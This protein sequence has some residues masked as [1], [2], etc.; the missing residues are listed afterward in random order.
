MGFTGFYATQMR[1]WA[2]SVALM[3][4]FTAFY[5]T[6][7][8]RY[9]ISVSLEMGF[10]GFHATKMKGLAISVALVVGFCLDLIL[11]E[12]KVVYNKYTS[13]IYN[14]AFRQKSNQNTHS[15]FADI[16]VSVL[17]P[18][19]PLSANIPLISRRKKGSP[20]TRIALKLT[21]KMLLISSFPDHHQMPINTQKQPLASKLAVA[22]Y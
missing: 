8:K 18:I 17:A 19:N 2:F 9:A 7:M 12:R 10:A 3:M 11:T 21:S 13:D 15:G 5:A 1:G 20:K 14:T 22:A 6:Q 16:F 4:S